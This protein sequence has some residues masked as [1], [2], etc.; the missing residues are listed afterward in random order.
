V[1]H[2]R[3]NPRHRG[4]SPAR[5]ML[6]AWSGLIGLALVA[7]YSDAWSSCD[8]VTGESDLACEIQS[9]S[10]TAGCSADGFAT[11]SEDAAA[12]R[13]PSSLGSRLFPADPT[14]P[15]APSLRA[16]RCRGDPSS[17]PEALHPRVNTRPVLRVVR[18]TR[19]L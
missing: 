17:S 14:S 6:L 16:A 2:L 15:V 1:A 8:P 18:S 9:H 7:G 11:V 12:L 5:S 19:P 10:T 13:P 3:C 4:A